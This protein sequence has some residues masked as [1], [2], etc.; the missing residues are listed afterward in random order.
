M[1]LGSYISK[2]VFSNMQNNKKVTKHKNLKY[3]Y[4][5]TVLE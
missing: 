1:L 5:K 4:I 3:K 2:D